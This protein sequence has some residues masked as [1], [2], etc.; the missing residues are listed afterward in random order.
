MLSKKYLVLIA[1]F[2]DIKVKKDTSKQVLK[3]D[4]SEKLVVADIL[5]RQSDDDYDDDDD[6]LE[7]EAA[8]DPIAQEESLNFNSGPR[9]L[10]IA[11]KL[12]DGY[13]KIKKQ[14]SNAEM[15]GLFVVEKQAERD[16]EM[17]K[18]DLD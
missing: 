4:L 8:A 18:L 15:I 5:P 3:D 10:R 17:R 14:E 2:F 11:L 7:S 1:D 9:D 12:K 6:E 13:F 16:I